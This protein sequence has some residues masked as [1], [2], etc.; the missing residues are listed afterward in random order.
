MKLLLFCLLFNPDTVAVEE[1]SDTSFFRRFLLNTN[2]SVNFNFHVFAGKI[3]SPNDI[4]AQEEYSKF[5]QY[6]SLGISPE[7]YSKPEELGYAHYKTFRF[8]AGYQFATTLRLGKYTPELIYG[9]NLLCEKRQYQTSFELRKQIIDLDYAYL[10]SQGYSRP[11]YYTQDDTSLRHKRVDELSCVIPVALRFPVKKRFGLETG[12]FL[13][14]FGY[15]RYINTGNT[16]TIHG[17]TYNLQPFQLNPY[18]AVCCKI[19]KRYVIQLGADFSKTVFL[20]FQI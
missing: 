20:S 8:M 12:V 10:I 13:K 6:Q 2:V 17:P 16:V 19:R 7:G 14:A 15:A 3:Q 1:E 9:I 18:L 4:N 5:I 11:I